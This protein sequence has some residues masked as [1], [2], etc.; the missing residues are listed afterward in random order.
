M[1]GEGRGG[2]GRG[3]EGRGGEGR[4]GVGSLPWV[5]GRGGV[6][7]VTGEELCGWQRRGWWV[8]GEGWV[9]GDW[10]YRDTCI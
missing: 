2:E 7:W 5:G 8:T 10:H 4:G 1:R 9:M 3:G 6:G